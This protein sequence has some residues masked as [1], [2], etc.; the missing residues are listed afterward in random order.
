MNRHGHSKVL[1]ICAHRPGRSPSQRYRFEQYI[2]FLGENGFEFTF[3]AL[4]DE[5]ED[6]LFY[7]HGHLLSKALVLLHSIRRRLKDLRRLKDFD[8]V[9]IQREASFFGSSFFERRA[10][11]AG[12]YVIFDFD[13]SIWLADTSPGNKKWEWLKRPQKFFDNIGYARQV[14]AG[15]NFLAARAREF[16]KHTLVIPTTIDTDLHRPIPEL[17]GKEFVTIGW[18]GSITTVKHFEILLPVLRKLKDELGENIRFKIL[19]AHPDYSLPS[20]NTITWSEENEVD[21][22][23]TFDVGVMPLPADEWANGKCGLKGLSY[24]SCGVPA[25]MSD[26]GVNRQIIS[27]G[28]NGF[29]ARTQEDWYALIKMLVNDRRLRETIGAEGRKS[30]IEGYSV[31]ANKLKYLEVF[32]KARTRTPVQGVTSQL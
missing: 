12:A 2:P 32:E 13:D 3:S 15:N 5:K 20:L 31:S 17:R 16:N 26:V 29:L 27:H 18:S 1:I 19:G 22:L 28:K 6:Q 7:K 30:V 21:E 10:F 11:I 4:L 25:I 23:N 24:M 8:I 14:I 9:F